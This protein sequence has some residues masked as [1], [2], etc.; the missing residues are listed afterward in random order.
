MRRI[1]AFHPF[2][3]S[4]REA[5]ERAFPEREYRVLSEPADFAR[6]LGEIELLLAMNPPRGHW[7]AAR[8]LRLIQMTGAG[9]DSVLP[10]PDLPAGVALANARGIHEPEMSEF[11]LALMLALAKRLP[12]AF[13]QQRGRRWKLF[14]TLRL[15]GATLGVLG[16][17]AIGRGIAARGAALGMRVIGTR[18][19]PEPLPG[20]DRVVGPEQTRWVLAESD[21]LV[22]VL[23]LT[24]ETRGLLDAAALA[25]MKPG[26]L[27][28]NVARGGIVDEAALAEALRARRLGGAALDVFETE[29]LGPESPLW[30]APGCLVTPH[31]AGLS[32]DYM[33]RVAEIFV[34]NARR[35]ERGDPIRNRVDPSRGY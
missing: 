11:A 35:I 15:A 23:P 12:R 28:V 3:E 17:G 10:A 27:L 2:G 29:P 5:V 24:P 34:D 4:V 19:S 18:R 33:E 16:L 20:V 9:V 30:E 22:V 6:E 25:E 7:A 1:H 8:R 26:A 32:R 21:V 13:E 14:G 31:L